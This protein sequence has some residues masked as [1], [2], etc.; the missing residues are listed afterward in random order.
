VVI[1]IGN[2]IQNNTGGIFITAKYS[3][4]T[5]RTQW[6]KMTHCWRRFAIFE[7][8]FNFFLCKM[9][10]AEFVDTCIILYEGTRN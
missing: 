5:W 9:Q 1:R 2:R 3:A 7:W 8:P 10:I 4:A 6:E